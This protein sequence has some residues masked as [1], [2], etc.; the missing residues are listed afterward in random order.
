MKM[1]GARRITTKNPASHLV[2]RALYG[3]SLRP[4]AISATSVSLQQRQLGGAGKAIDNAV[5]DLF[6]RFAEIVNG[7]KGAA[8]MRCQ[9]LAATTITEDRRKGCRKHPG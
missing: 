3:S 9:F 4:Y 8:H 5:A 1:C 6:D 2:C 7:R